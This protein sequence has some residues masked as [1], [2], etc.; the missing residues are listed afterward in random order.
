MVA[1]LRAMSSADRLPGLPAPAP[2]A[3]ARE[4]ARQFEA[5]FM[6]EL[7]RGLRGSLPGAPLPGV[8]TG[9]A[10]D[11]LGAE[12][13]DAHHAQQLAGRPGGLAEVI[14]R[15]LERMGAPASAASPP[16]R[17]PMAAVAEPPA[18]PARPAP[19]VAAAA[20]AAG[21]GQGTA[22][23]FLATHREAAERVAA[24]SGIP[25]DYLLAQAA[26]ETGWGRRTPRGADGAESHNLF[27]IK[28]GAGWRGPVVTTATTEVID[29]EPRRVQARFRAY[30]SP[31]ESLRDYARLVGGSPRYAAAMRATDDPAAWAR[32]LQQAG[33]ATDPAYAD[34]LLRAIRT[35]RSLGATGDRA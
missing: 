1:D 7:L 9:S 6:Q 8:D 11:G 31:E 4:V 18:V 26:H 34:K 29:G 30:A 35:T 14:A 13:L 24:E 5:L 20:A 10:R 25:A 32:S 27:G 16:A 23:R 17:A 19:T 3:S 22:R 12:M 33:Y 15:Q 2:S 28:A 21:A